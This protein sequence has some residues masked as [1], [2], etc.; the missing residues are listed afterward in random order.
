MIVDFA[1]IKK[2][3]K[4]K[5]LLVVLLFYFGQK[6]SNVNFLKNISKLKEKKD[7]TKKNWTK[8]QMKSGLRFGGVFFTKK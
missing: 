2:K 3:K 5:C 7:S 6:M 4:S 1:K 8:V